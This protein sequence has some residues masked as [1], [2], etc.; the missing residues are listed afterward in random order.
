MSVGKAVAGASAW[1]WEQFG[2]QVKPG[3][4]SFLKRKWDDAKEDSER[5]RYADKKWKD[6]NWGQAA[7]RYKKHMQEIYGHIR[8]IGTTEPI[9]IGDIFTDVYILEK[10]QAY[11]RFDI[12]KLHEAQK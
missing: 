12:T 3:F 11:N 2:D 5:L 4:L 9:P 6:F 10:P 8:V 7:E 1:A